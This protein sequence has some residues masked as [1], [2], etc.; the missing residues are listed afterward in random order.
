MPPR[1]RDPGPECR[2]RTESHSSRP[3]ESNGIDDERC[4]N[5]ARADPAES[6]YGDD[7]ERLEPSGAPP[8]MPKLGERWRRR[9][10]LAF[11]LGA[12]AGLLRCGRR[13]G[14]LARR[15]RDVTI[16]SSPRDP[17]KLHRLMSAQLV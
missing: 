14:V 1:D 13:R 11:L 5:E 3:P 17:D 8:A 10:V 2:T 7:P 12:Y 16:G 9:V 4:R 6:A 15:C